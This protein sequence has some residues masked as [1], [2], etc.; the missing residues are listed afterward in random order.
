[1]TE[2]TRYN[3]NSIRHPDFLAFFERALCRFVYAFNSW[4]I[5]LLMQHDTYCF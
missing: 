4:S 1:M 5:G 2:T 3:A